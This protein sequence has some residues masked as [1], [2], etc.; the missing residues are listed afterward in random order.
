MDT[1]ER[2]AWG[3]LIRAARE[4]QGYKQ[5]DVAEMA[6]VSRRT[7]GSIERGDTTAQTDVL[8]RILA[9]LNLTPTAALDSDVRSFT[10][11]LGPLLQRLGQEER[12]AVMPV[13]TDL[14]A[15]AL[16]DSRETG[17]IVLDLSKASTSGRAPMYAF[18]DAAAARDEDREKPT[19][20]NE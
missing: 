2:R 15:S 11:M 3:P 7:L 18:D 4:A 8:R 5:V 16:K 17:V 12:A 6:N 14:V 1:A 19:L 10:A 20:G 13:I 9:S